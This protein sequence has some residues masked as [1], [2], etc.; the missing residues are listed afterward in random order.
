MTPLLLE[1]V[2][3]IHAQLV[4]VQKQYIAAKGDRE[5]KIIMMFEITKS[6]AEDWSIYYYSLKSLV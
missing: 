4:E 2:R 5:D 1:N 3:R 6:C